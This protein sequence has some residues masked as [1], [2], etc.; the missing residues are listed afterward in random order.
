MVR[1]EDFP[2]CG[3]ELGDC[4]GSKYG[5]DEYIKEQAYRRMELEDMGIFPDDDY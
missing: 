1:C 2:C 4:D 3:H 5:S